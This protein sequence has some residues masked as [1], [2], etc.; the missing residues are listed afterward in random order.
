MVIILTFR[1]KSLCFIIRIKCSKA[2]GYIYTNNSDKQLEKSACLQFLR[3]KKMKEKAQRNDDE[4]K[5]RGIEDC[6][7]L[8]EGRSRKISR[9]SW[10]TKSRSLLVLSNT[11]KSCND[12]A[13]PDWLMWSHMAEGLTFIFWPALFIPKCSLQRV[14]KL[15]GVFPK[16]EAWQPGHWNL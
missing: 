13:W 8:S 5:A 10:I 16:Y 3:V 7:E 4:N 14:I 2:R 15:R 11:E 9:L 1:S 12:A 6:W